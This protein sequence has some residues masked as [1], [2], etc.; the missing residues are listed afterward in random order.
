M[1]I[2]LAVST[3]FAKEVLAI[4]EYRYYTDKFSDFGID[5]LSL[6][7][8][9]NTI[10][11]NSQQSQP[12]FLGLFYNKIQSAALLDRQYFVILSSDINSENKK[13]ILSVLGT[14]NAK[15]I[16]LICD[17][18]FRM[19]DNISC[20]FSELGSD[21][22]ADYSI[23]GVNIS[24]KKFLG[25]TLITIPALYL[26]TP[27][28]YSIFGNYMRAYDRSVYPKDEL[29]KIIELKYLNEGLLKLAQQAIYILILIAVLRY[30]FVAII[31]KPKIFIESKTYESILV[32]IENFFMGTSKL[33]LGF[34]VPLLIVYIVSLMSISI[35]DVGSISLEYIANYIGGTYSVLVGE[36][37]LSLSASRLVLFPLGI[38]IIFLGILICVPLITGFIKIGMNKIGKVNLRLPVYKFSLAFLP[39]AL[40]FSVFAFSIDKFILVILVL[41]VIYVFM[42]ITSEK[43]GV[44]MVEYSRNQKRIILIFVSMALTFG[45]YLRY[46]SIN[47]NI[48][49][50]NQKLINDGDRI[51]ILPYTKI[52]KDGDIFDKYFVKVTDAIFI[53]KYMVANSQYN[54]IVSTPLSNF[55]S[56]NNFVVVNSSSDEFAQEF[57]QNIPFR[58][59]Y[60][61]KFKGDSK[62]KFF[63]FENTNSSERDTFE[64]EL[65]YKCERDLGYNKFL[66]KVF[67]TSYL[68]KEEPFENIEIF[69]NPSCDKGQVINVRVPVSFRAAPEGT[70]LLNFITG[71]IQDVEE[72][73]GIDAQIKIF[74]NNSEVIMI[75]ISYDR[76]SKIFAENYINLNGEL[77]AYYF[78][79]G[80]TITFKRNG[81]SADLSEFVNSL[82][83]LKLVKSPIVIWSTRDNYIIKNFYEN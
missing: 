8:Y 71:D 27:E 75:P 55:N 26:L 46:G 7:D 40:L 20:N 29:D 23:N 54:E 34:F 39:I 21:T 50:P 79:Q 15:T 57:I 41:G 33:Y 24:E 65:N 77:T 16:I 30:L 66:I 52:Y 1:F 13:D 38:L 42:L 69:N 17:S 6:F 4:N 78:G 11:N 72:V 48:K 56:T 5:A 14:V 51:I 9:R 44:G 53:N 76:N 83:K 82:I 58:S 32:S 60:M 61:G 80:E 73:S 49:W 43:S 45:V 25:K 31:D 81:D 47:N 70:V 63:L 10:E 74:K 19:S 3:A 37:I 67:H 22:S 35:K 62:S 28:Y 64:V 12:S 68:S 36:N 2:A 59:W 18:E